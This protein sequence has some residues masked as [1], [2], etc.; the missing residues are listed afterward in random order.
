MSRVLLVGGSLRQGS[1]NQ[2]LL[3]HLATYLPAQTTVQ[4]LQPASVALPLFNQDIER[5][6][7]HLQAAAQIHA[8][9]SQAEGLLVAVPEYNGQVTAYF[10]NLIDWMSRLPYVSDDFSNAFLDKPVLLCSAST[11]HTGGALGIQSARQ[12]L[13]YVG[14][15]VLGGAICVSHVQ[16]KFNGQ[17]W[18]MS[19]ELSEMVAFHMQRFNR[20]LG[21]VRH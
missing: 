10:K 19:A 8:Q 4:T 3:H 20:V 6:P 7:A 2:A 11:G 14:G 5:M 16:Q 13:A 18:T 17:A 21:A 1:Y 9:F 12:L 15:S